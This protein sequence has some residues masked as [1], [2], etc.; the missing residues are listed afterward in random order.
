[1]PRPRLFLSGVL[2]L[3][4]GVLALGGSAA[5]AAEPAEGPFEGKTDTGYVVTFDV[6]EGGVFDLFFTLEWDYCGPAPVHVKGRF[7]DI[8]PSGHFA[9]DQGQWNFDGTFVSP[10]EVQGTATF[11]NHPLAGCGKEA[12]PYTA[13]LRTGPPPTVPTCKGDQL[14]TRLH[15]L[16][17]GVGYHFLN[18]VLENRGSRCAVRGYPRLRLRGVG[19]K[20]LP[21]R[22][23]HE[24]PVRRVTMEPKEAIVAT[25]RW[26][27]R[28]GPGE[29]RRGRCE[30]VARSV[31]ARIPGGIVR[32]FPW[33]WGPVCQRG[34][35]RVSAFG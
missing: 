20:P 28:P 24:G 27:A 21:T 25:V 5:A 35:L 9:I 15:A 22:I 14:K 33:R 11:L 3:A 18:L 31:I 10:T 7:A 30:P 2:A 29:P 6:R 23:V 32:R 16:Y 4:L 8:D 13:R 12:V 17:P 34:A 1:M 26:D 19:D